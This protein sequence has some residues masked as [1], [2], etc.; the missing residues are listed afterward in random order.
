[1]AHAAAQGIRA[2]RAHADVAAAF[3]LAGLPVS[4]LSVGSPADFFLVRGESL[5]QVVV[6][7]PEREVVVRGG[8]VVARDGEL[9]GN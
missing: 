1:M 9:V 6:D 3:G 7:V 5:A 4:D 2:L 8:T